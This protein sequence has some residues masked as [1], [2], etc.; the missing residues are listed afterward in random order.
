M[1]A[2]VCVFCLMLQIPSPQGDLQRGYSVL[3]EEKINLKRELKNS[4][5]LNN[6]GA[7]KE[8]SCSLT[9]AHAASGMLPAVVR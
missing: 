1:G 6:L 8:C 3:R 2:M 7:A 5:V 9:A 4:P